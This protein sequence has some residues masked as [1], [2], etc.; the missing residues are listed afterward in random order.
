MMQAKGNMMRCYTTAEK[1][2]DW[3]GTRELAAVAGHTTGKFPKV[4]R[5]VEL[6]DGRAEAQR[7]RYASGLHLVADELEFIKLV[8]YKIVRLA[9]LG[10]AC[11]ECQGTGAGCRACA[12][13]GATP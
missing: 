2:Y 6:E 12:G 8:G 13:E 1:A 9:R 5:L 11:R 10:V 3:F 4:V 7:A